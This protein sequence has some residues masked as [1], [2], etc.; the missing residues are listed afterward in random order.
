MLFRA[1]LTPEIKPAKN[2]FFECAQNRFYR[3]ENGGG[4]PSFP[5]NQKKVAFP[6]SGS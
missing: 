4:L 5:V 3:F 1:V 6:N 2:G